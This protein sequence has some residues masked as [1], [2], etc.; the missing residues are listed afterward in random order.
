MHKLH[1]FLFWGK[2]GLADKIVNLADKSTFS[3]DKTV[4][5]ADKL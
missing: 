5:S 1:A 4:K 3:A 2:K